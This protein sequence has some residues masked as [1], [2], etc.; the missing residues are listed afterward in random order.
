MRTKKLIKLFRFEEKRRVDLALGANT[1]LHPEQ[2]WLQL[3]EDSEGQYPLD[4]DLQVKTWVANPDAV[5]AWAGFQVDLD[6]FKNDAGSIVTSVGYR[7]GDGTDEYFW[8]G[9]AWVVAGASDWNTEGE[10]AA[11]ISTFPATEKKLQVV[12]NLATTDADF[13][14][15]VRAVRVLYESRIEFQEDI[16]YRSMVR[17]L[18]NELRPISDYPVILL[19]D[20]TAVDLEN[21]Y[22]LQTPYNVVSIDSVFNETDDPDWQTDLF[23][24]YNPTT[25]V[26]TLTGSVPAGKQLRIRF[27]YE[28]EVAVRTSR[29]YEELE[30]VPQVLLE[31]IELVDA[32][33]VPSDEEVLNK[34]T[35]QGFR[36]F[37]PL[38]GDLEINLAVITDK[39]TDQMRLADEVKRYFANHPTLH[40]T[41][42]DEEY[43]LWLV[44][45]YE[46]MAQSRGPD[47]YL[48]RMMFRI[49][50]VLFWTKDAAAAFAVLALNLAGDLNVVVTDEESGT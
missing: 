12:L 36:V 43:R 45:E 39:Q 31:S 35:G 28:P 8:N 34:A 41:G 5:T 6:N 14:P 4:A 49:V 42:L 29:D 17:S 3:K 1:R 32:Y 2:H 25:K 37:A 50:D 16:I 33:E 48:G 7:L 27:T 21:D 19:A 44:D 47:I 9:G 22:P 38:M 46:L 26:V 40:S 30:K 11:N 10:V 23:S 24:S 20:S 15:R 18:R 13:T